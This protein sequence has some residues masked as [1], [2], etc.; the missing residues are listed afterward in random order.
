MLVTVS[1][2]ECV[3]ASGLGVWLGL[4]ACGPVN[5][6]LNG[7]ETLSKLPPIRSTLVRVEG[8]QI[9]MLPSSRQHGCPSKLSSS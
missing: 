3:F 6:E 7:A 8:S 1:E 4:E 5:R 2:K 9:A